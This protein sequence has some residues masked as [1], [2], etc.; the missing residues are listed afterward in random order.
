MLHPMPTA[1]N[2][3]TVADLLAHLSVPAERIR[4]QPQPGTATEQDVLA[5]YTHEKRRCE[6]VDGIL[7]EKTMGF[8]ESRLAV[9][10]IC[11]LE[12]FAS[13]HDLGIVLGSDALMRMAPGLVRIPDVSFVSWD[14]L[15][16]RQIPRDA[17]P[18][19]V[20]DLAVE[21]LSKS[22]S[23]TEMNRKLQT[24]L[25]TCAWCGILIPRLAS[26]GFLPRRWTKLS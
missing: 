23:P 1:T 16:N 6:L 5:A 20:P 21:V 19:L 13:K 11:L 4:L 12:E 10:L 14:R 2:F 22:N 15:P 18:D 7:V 8:F 26:C 9:I 24:W 17:V 25:P 3:P